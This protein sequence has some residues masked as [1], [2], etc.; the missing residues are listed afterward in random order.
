M[1]LKFLVALFLLLC[2]FFIFNTA[3]AA[4]GDIYIVKV[5]DAISPGT[6]EF[7]E[8]GRTML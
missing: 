4:K 3:R 5:A 6:A 7:T 1:K 2:G 8:Y